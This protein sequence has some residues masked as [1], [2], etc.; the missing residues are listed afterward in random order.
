MRLTSDSNCRRPQA[1]WS[2]RHCQQ[3]LLTTAVKASTDC[4]SRH[5][6]TKRIARYSQ[7]TPTKKYED[8]STAAERGSEARISTSLRHKNDKKHSVRSFSGT[9][10]LYAFRRRHR[11]NARHVIRHQPLRVRCRVFIAHL[12]VAGL[13]WKR[14]S[15]QQRT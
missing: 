13:S 5:L 15:H 7:F 10:Q 4:R 2:L 8:G 6:A 12:S 14:T 9:S 11:C 1:Y 3:L